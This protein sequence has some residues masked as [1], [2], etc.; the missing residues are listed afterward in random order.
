MVDPDDIQERQ[1]QASDHLDYFRSIG[2]TVVGKPGMRGIVAH[3][4]Q[5]ELQFWMVTR[6]ENQSDISI[7]NRRH[8]SARLTARAT[9][10][11]T[12]QFTRIWIWGNTWEPLSGYSMM[13]HDSSFDNPDQLTTITNTTPNLGWESRREMWRE[14]RP[15]RRRLAARTQQKGEERSGGGNYRELGS[16]QFRGDGYRG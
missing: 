13:D 15:S 9:L 16:T 8:R 5:A 6:P 3:S 7:K 2:K 10:I 12:S 1:R 11:K 14:Y 4:T